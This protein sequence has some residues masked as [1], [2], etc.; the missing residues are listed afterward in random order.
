MEKN[1]C[2]WEYVS[3]RTE[4]PSHDHHHVPTVPQQRHPHWKSNEVSLWTAPL[5]DCS[6]S[7]AHHAR[8]LSPPALLRSGHILSMTVSVWWSAIK[9]KLHYWRGCKKRPLVSSPETARHHCNSQGRR[10]K[11][12]I[13]LVKEMKH[14]QHP[15]NDF[16]PQTRADNTNRQFYTYPVQ[17][18]QAESSATL[19]RAVRLCSIE[20]N[21]TI[22]G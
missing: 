18:K 19:L 16:L 22:Y 12:T 5:S 9:V 8:G 2:N 10:E 6:P 15:I 14:A 3:L 7:T 21:G 4:S 11:A 1:Q 13:Q 17:N 20:L